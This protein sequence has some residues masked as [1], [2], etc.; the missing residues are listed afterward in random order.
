MIAGATPVSRASAIRIGSFE[1]S[2]RMYSMMALLDFSNWAAEAA[3]PQS[4]TSFLIAGVFDTCLGF[5]LP[6]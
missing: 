2:R 6:R 1:P 4:K 3:E 5:A